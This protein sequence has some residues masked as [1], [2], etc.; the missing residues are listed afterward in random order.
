MR[1]ARAQDG[2]AFGVTFTNAALPSPVKLDVELVE[3]DRVT[4]PNYGLAVQDEDKAVDGIV[5]DEYGNPREYHV[6]RSHPGAR[7]ASAKDL[8]AYDRVPA[9]NV[10]HWYRQDRPGQRR[11]LPDLLPALPLFAQLR[12]YT[13]V[14]IAAAE[15]AANIAVL[16]KTNAPAGGARFRRGPAASGRVSAHTRRGNAVRLPREGTVRRP[17]QF[18]PAPACRSAW[19]RQSPLAG[20]SSPFWPSGSALRAGS[21]QAPRSGSGQAALTIA[22]MLALTGAG[23]CGQAVRTRARSGSEGAFSAPERQREGHAPAG[24]FSQVFGGQGTCGFGPS[25][26]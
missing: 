5:Y 12:R 9:A 24:A 8:T 22:T 23:R 6:L 15:S 14:V 25:V 16:M 18:V 1:A 11:G 13:L 21:G 3:A 10:L 4:T 19:R 17:R 2:E 20:H 7:K 26:P